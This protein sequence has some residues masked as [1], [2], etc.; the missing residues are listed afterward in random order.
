MLFFFPAFSVYLVKYWFFLQTVPCCTVTPVCCCC[1]KLVVTYPWEMHVWRTAERE[2][3][4]IQL[5]LGS[6]GTTGSRGQR[7]G[8]M[9]SL[10]FSPVYTLAASQ[11][12][13][14][15]GGMT[16]ALKKHW[17]WF[18]VQSFDTVHFKGNILKLISLAV[19]CYV[20]LSFMKPA[21]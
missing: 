10:G 20:R 21:L 4:V 13:P 5:H 11:T 7:G 2:T 14:L 1:F 6:T 12:Q 15:E 16:F 18:T 17:L 3:Q 19:L 8:C 9:S